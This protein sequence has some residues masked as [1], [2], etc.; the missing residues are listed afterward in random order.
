MEWRS[1]AWGW[2]PWRCSCDDEQVCRSGLDR[3]AGGADTTFPTMS[4]RAAVAWIG[5][6][7]AAGYV[8]WRLAAV[9]WDPV[10]IFEL[11]EQYAQ[12][13]SNGSEGYDG[14]FTYF[15]ATQPDPELVASKLDVPAYRYQRILLPLLGRVVGLG[16]RSWI[17]WAL[18][19]VNLAAH[20]LGTWAV[21][22]LLAKRGASEWYGLSYGLWVGLIASVGIGLAEPLAYGL[23]SLAIL[24]ALHGKRIILA[25][26]VLCLA[27]LAKETA[28]IFLI[29]LLLAELAGRRDRRALAAIAGAAAVHVAWQLWLLSTFG[30]LGI[31]SGGALASPFELIP[32]M[33]LARIGSVSMAALG[34]YLLVFGPAVIVPSI[35]GVLH[36]VRDWLRGQRGL[37]V[38]ALL[39]NALVIMALP[40]STFREPLGIVR[41]AD[42]LVLATLYY[43]A[44]RQSQRPLRY[45][46]FWTAWLA[47]LVSR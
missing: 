16:N 32:F 19:L 42:G 15:I 11:G 13:N 8:V 44:T 46:L 24:L 5:A 41:V 36:G 1:P 21:A 34:F 30:S 7:V 45:S 23:T 40:F 6:L 4:K 9:G 33:G 22:G 37:E 2:W 10:G 28:L 43:A 12:G 18:I 27:G 38:Y 31:G 25:A 47:L 20:W 3:R 14:Q 17:P 29:A 26:I 35:W 39:L